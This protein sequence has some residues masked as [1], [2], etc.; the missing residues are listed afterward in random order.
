MKFQDHIR[1]FKQWKK[2][3]CRDLVVDKNIIIIFHKSYLP[4]YPIIK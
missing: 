2:L 4:T 3:L 1:S